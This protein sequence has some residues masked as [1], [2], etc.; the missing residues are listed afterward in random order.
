M[1]CLAVTYTVKPG[2]EA[3]AEQHLRSL[4]APSRAEPGCRMYVVHRSTEDPRT[5]FLYEQ[6]DDQ[7]ALDSHLASPHFEQHG[8]YGV[9]RLAESRV[10]VTCTPFGD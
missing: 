5:F 7:T 8:R 4:I 9:R 2:T 6:Y 3:E 10:A 1:I